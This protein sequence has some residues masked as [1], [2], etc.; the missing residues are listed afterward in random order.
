MNS[1]H[2]L[3]LSILELSVIFLLCSAFF[4]HS[5]IFAVAPINVGENI[6]VVDERFVRW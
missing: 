5:S 2:K 1:Y 3:K 4:L 6:H